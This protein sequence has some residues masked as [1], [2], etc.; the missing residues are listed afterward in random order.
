MN[1]LR[2]KY[3]TILFF[4]FNKFIKRKEKAKQNYILKN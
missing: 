3:N 1:K 2:L 4:K